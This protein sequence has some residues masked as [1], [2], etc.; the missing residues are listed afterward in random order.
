MTS[1]INRVLGAL[2]FDSGVFENIEGDRRATWQAAG[3]V[4]LSSVASGI[5]FGGLVDRRFSTFAILS[6]VAL[7]TWAVWAVMIL[8]VG[9]RVL[10][11]PDT[12][13][14]LGEVLRTLGFAA[15]PGFFQVFALFPPATVAVLTVTT[16][17]MFVAMV[18]AVH[19][20]LDYHGLGRAIAVC[21]IAAALAAAMAVPI[22]LLLSRTVLSVS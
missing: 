5:G 14:D 6:G 18:I 13:A 17:W 22:A 7:L 4:V 11:E 2:T 19:H 21:G 15:A 9:T 1:V 20:A 16:I 10:P 8:Q 12:R 3:I